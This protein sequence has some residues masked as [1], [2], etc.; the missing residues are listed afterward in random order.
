MS[1]Y[2]VAIDKTTSI[3]D[4]RA[5]YFRNLI[6]A[7]VTLSFGSV[8]WAVV[9]WAVSPLAGLLLLLPLC[10]IFF[11]LDARLL[12]DW[13]SYL[14]EAWIRKNIDIRAFCDAVTA[15]PNIPKETLASMLTT[16]PSAPDLV[17]EQR[18]SASTREGVAAA[19]TGV[20]ALE[21]DAIALK[22]AAAT[23]LS[24]AVVVALISRRWEPLL[25]SV[26]PL[27]LPVLGECLKRRRLADMKQ[28][29]F[30]ARSKPDF[31]YEKY[32]ELVACL[33]WGPIPGLD[34]DGFLKS[35]Q[36]WRGKTD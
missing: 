12:G 2:R 21:S 14:L 34:R 8:T 9:T 32:E 36:N 18:A 6:I 17:A 3:I 11:F 10:G 23:M 4:L 31:N 25:A 28:R 24:C 33:Q 19:V 20:H 15:V 29:T 30:A 7:V 16:L 22:S 26:A 13:R 35:V 27:M 1:P 5:R